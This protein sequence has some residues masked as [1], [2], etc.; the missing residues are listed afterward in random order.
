MLEDERTLA[1][2][3]EQ[4]L[5]HGERK[6]S[7]VSMGWDRVTEKPHTQLPGEKHHGR[8]QGERS[9]EHTAAQVTDQQKEG[10][11]LAWRTHPERT[12]TEEA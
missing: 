10:K 8:A 3:T 4:M 1:W 7:R 11:V 5:K 9:A 12:R 6:R 2:E